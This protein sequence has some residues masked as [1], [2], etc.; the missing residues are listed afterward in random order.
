MIRVCA[1]SVNPLDW[2]LMR[3]EP[4][5]LRLM[6]GVRKPRLGRPGVDVAGRVESRGRGVTQLAPGDAVFGTCRGALAEFAC[7]SAT[8]VVIKPENISFEHAAAVPI[9]AYTA[10]QGLRDH[11][12]IRGG[13]RVLING[14]SGGVGTFAVQIAK[15][16][17]SEVT[18]VCSAGNVDLVRSL[19]ADHVIDYG[20]EDFT[21]AGARYDLILDLIGNH[22][23]LALSRTLR[24]GGIYV[25]AGAGTN[26]STMGVL[27]GLITLPTVSLIARRTLVTM[28]A[29]R[30]AADLA[31]IRELLAAGTV[32]PVI[33]GRYSLGEI[34]DAIRYL[35]SGRAR[36]KVVIVLGS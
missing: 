18:G 16:F 21:R 2:H 10:L 13:Q 1:A 3:G 26:P 29:E 5:I 24:R 32:T 33:D 4:R 35:E 23:L 31:G 27:A 6:T 34:A 19:G 7:A 8:Q 20:R 9:A 17:G 12:R 15:S 14:A 25:G 36:G 22:G 11:G 30:R 28:L